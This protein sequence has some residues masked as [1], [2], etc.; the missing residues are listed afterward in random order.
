[1]MLRMLCLFV[2]VWVLIASSGI[3]AVIHVPADYPSI[4]EAIAAAEELDQII[5]APGTYVENVRFM[6]K[7]VHVVSSDGAESTVIDGNQEGS[8]AAFT[9][10]ESRD[11]VLEGF[12]LTNGTGTLFSGNVLG[13]GILCRA[14]SEPIIRNNIIRDNEAEKGGGIHCVYSSPLIENNIITQNRSSA[15]NHA[16]AIRCGNNSS[17]V[18]RNNEITDNED[19][20]IYF[21]LCRAEI[22]KNLISGNPQGGVQCE[23]AEAEIIDNVVSD[24]ASSSYH[25]PG[26]SI[27][28]SS[29]L[30]E[31]NHISGNVNTYAIG[32]GIRVSADDELVEIRHN[33]IV[34][35][36]AVHGE[37]GGI[38]YNLDIDAPLII[39]HNLIVNNRALHG[40]GISGWDAALT[41]KNNVFIENNAAEVGG[42]I[43]LRRGNHQ[44]TS[45]RFVG[46]IAGNS[47][48]GIFMEVQL[49]KGGKQYFSLLVNNVMENNSTTLNGGAICSHNLDLELV[50]NTI[51]NNSTSFIG[52]GG[53]LYAQAANAEIV[54]TIFWNNPSLEGAQVGLGNFLDPSVLIIYH[55]LLE[56]GEAGVHVEHG[57][58]LHWGVGMI[59]ADPHFVDAANNDYHL[60]YPSPC[61]NAGAGS[62]VTESID[63]EG[64]PRI[65]HG[66]VDIGADEFH[67]HLYFTGDATPGGAIEGKIV[68]LPDTWPV[69]LFLGSGMLENPIQH[70]WGEFWL[71]EPWWA[72]P[73][74]PMPA[75]GVL[76][77][78]FTIP[79]NPPAP[80]E[81]SLQAL[82]GKG[83][84]ALTNPCMLTVD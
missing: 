56:G 23:D 50:N 25:A 2:P 3:S 79:L 22:V 55:S 53:G 15:S 77:M 12:T 26:I 70:A 66:I 48:G 29:A 46:N 80:Y 42:A 43:Y 52:C 4:Q 18:I 51:C 30:I 58:T 71:K 37:G 65:A 57:S 20:G 62:V 60:T 17:P 6:G 61:L 75:S 69:G 82:V 28:D 78:P 35:N 49:G 83:P 11:A 9:Y 39:E 64:D 74:I 59:D 19:V 41:C 24:N 40:G 31:G 45:N 13:G 54:N 7:D 10:Y 73:L 38:Y 63:M 14:N 47:G 36:V 8:V 33:V 21:E 27:M 72:Y 44:I 84:G 68:G 32:A 67:T 76:V 5:V 34:G 1:M 81:I 16:C